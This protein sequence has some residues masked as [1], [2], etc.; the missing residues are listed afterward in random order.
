MINNEIS[1]Y[2]RLGGEQGVRELVDRFYN[3]MDTLPEAQYIR[4]MHPGDLTSSRD[5][6]YKFL[7][8]WLGGP[9]LYMQE[10]GHPRLRMRHMPF[11]I[12]DAERDAWMHCMKLA[13]AETDLDELQRDHLVS[14]FWQ[15]ANHMRNAER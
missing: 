2:N 4:K 9:Q 13:L 8:G 3:L 15:T 7:S 1:P 5:K 11:T 12:G 10:Y 14:S 6:L